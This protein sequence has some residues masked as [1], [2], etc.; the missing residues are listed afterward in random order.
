MA[1]T[2]QTQQLIYAMGTEQY[3]LNVHVHVDANLGEISSIC[4]FKC[5]NS[6]LMLEGERL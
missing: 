4:L 5:V 1:L 3:N 6:N 2:Q